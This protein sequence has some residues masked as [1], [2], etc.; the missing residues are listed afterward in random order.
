MVAS[1]T[2]RQA[3]T[4]AV[5]APTRGVA[6]Q[7]GFSVDEGYCMRHLRWAWVVAFAI[8]HLAACAPP[9]T[10][11]DTATCGIRDHIIIGSIAQQDSGPVG[12][13]RVYFG[14]PTGISATNFF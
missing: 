11:E 10:C 5:A 2:S 6:T 8:R 12:R 4:P 9:L 14:S 13:A 3:W 1:R 7:L